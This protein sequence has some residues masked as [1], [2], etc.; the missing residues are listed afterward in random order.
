MLRRWFSLIICC[1]ISTAYVQTA[2]AAGELPLPAA[3]AFEISGFM[4]Q[5]NQ[6]TL[7]W[8]LAPGYYLYKNEMKFV[9]TDKN[10]VKTG[11]IVLPQGETRHDNLHGEFQA[12][13]GTLTI[14]ITLTPPVHGRLNLNIIYQGC[15][16]AGFCY[17]PI[18]QNLSVNT[19][20]ITTPADLTDNIVQLGQHAPGAKISE[21]S[22]L[23]TLLQGHRLLVILPSFLL[24]G[25]LL[26]F[27]PCVLPM[28]PILSSIIVG[29]GKNISTRKAFTLSLAYVSGM[30]L[31]Y[32]SA[33]VLIA[34]AGGSVQVALQKPWVIAAFCG[35]FILLALSLFGFYEIK[36]PAKL[37][38]R[39][40]S[41][42][43]R[44]EG[45]TYVGVFLMGAFSTLVVSPCVSAPLVGVLAYIAESG[46]V[47]L[48]GTALLALGLGMGLPLLLI[49]TSAGKL[50]PKS[51]PWMDKIK[52]LFGLLMLGVAI[53]MASRILS[54]MTVLILWGVLTLIAAIWVWQV[55]HSK[56]IWHKLHQG[57]GLL[58][59]S[60]SFILM[61]G[62]LI[63]SV[64]PL[65]PLS[66]LYGL[67]SV[68][69]TVV[70]NMQQL[71]QQLAAAKAQKKKVLLDFYADWC[72]S[73]VDMER[74]VFT[75]ASI[76][77]AL[78]NYVLLRADVTKN[79]AFDQALL[80]RFDVIAPPTFIFFNEGGEPIPQQEIVGEVNQKEFLADLQSICTSRN[81]TC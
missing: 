79:D 73:C 59:L 24:L 9:P 43:H 19:D 27:T 80:K 64:D 39:V 37:H 40:A 75:Q 30:A 72:V 35:L 77:R 66:G 68:K 3:Q 7:Q 46:N 25:L 15:S 57:L 13:T 28:V 53:W 60:Y 16:S 32:A 2:Q 78:S 21:Q 69:F 44:H 5:N 26:A 11:Q 8:R 58:L 33:G 38:Q 76:H 50:L 29:Y 42:S 74:Q 54:E 23:A 49:G 22:Y 45:G 52:Q 36:L 65:H 67:P 17:P 1:F 18:K 6:L 70:N 71:N 41:F 48:G 81:E 55:R 10:Q 31:A 51:G 34:L 12:Y 20:N 62:A 63:G 14:Q 47:V 61:G 4:G 56:K